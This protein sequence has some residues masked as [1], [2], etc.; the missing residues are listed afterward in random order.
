MVCFIHHQKQGVF[1]H[2]L[3]LGED[4][5]Y[6]IFIFINQVQ[7]LFYNTSVGND[8]YGQ[9]LGLGSIP[10]SPAEAGRSVG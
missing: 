4:P 9:V 8:G 6:P 1:H 5:V 2:C 10:A 3:V 7:V